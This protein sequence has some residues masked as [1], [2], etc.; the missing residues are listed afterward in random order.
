MPRAIDLLVDEI[1]P[2][3][4]RGKLTDL[5]GSNVNDFLV[6]L[7][8]NY[9]DQYKKIS[10]D[11]G[12]L[13][14][15]AAYIQGETLGLED[16]EPVVDKPLLLAAMNDEIA[17]AKQKLGNTDQFKK[18][19]ESIWVKY[20]DMMLKN[21]MAGAK[22]TNNKIGH[23]VIS[24]ARGKPSQM[25]AMLTTP[26]LYADSKGD[27]VPMFVENS[28]A[29]G[30][31]PLEFAAGMF[32]ARASV[33]STKA[34]TA[35][36]GDYGKLLSQASARLVVTDK[37]CGVQ[38]GLAY[39][40]DD[41]TARNRVLAK[42]VGNFKA[43]TLLTREVIADLKKSNVNKVVARSPLT[44][45]ADGLCSQCVGV[46]F[47]KRFPK[48]GE[49]IGI[50][51]A[52]ALS[53][54][55]TQGALC[56]AKGTMV[57]MANYS[58]KAIEDINIG[59]IVLGADKEGN[60]FA[61]RV[62][63]TFNQGIKSVYSTSFNIGSSSQTVNIVATLDHKILSNVKN[64]GK[65]YFDKYNGAYGFNSP[66]NYAAQ[67]LPLSTKNKEFSAVLLANNQQ[68]G[69]INNTALF[70]GIFAGDGIKFSTKN[71]T[72]DRVKFSCADPELISDLN[73]YLA[74][75]GMYCKK[76][77]RGFDYSFT[78]LS[79]SNNT[80]KDST[81]GKFVSSEEVTHPLK[82]A[83]I[84]NEYA[85]KY[86]YEKEL[87]KE[88][89][90]WDKSSVYEFIAG[91]LATDGCIKLTKNSA[92]IS[93]ASTSKKLIEG[94]KLL[95]RLR[96]GIYSSKIHK[97]DRDTRTLYTLSINRLDQVYKLVTHLN[98]P[99][100]KK[101]K[102]EAVKALYQRSK[103]RHPENFVRA[104]RS[105]VN[106]V[107]EVECYDI[108]V[109]HEDHLFV[110]E[111]NMIVSNSAK[112]TGGQ[113]T[114]KGEYGGF[115]ILSQFVQSPSE[116]IHKAI[117]SD[118]DGQVSQIEEAPQGGY[119]VTINNKP[120]YVKPGYPLTVKVGQN[121]EAGTP[122][123]EGIVDARDVVEKVGLGA[124]RKYWVD[125]IQKIYKDS[126]LYADKKNLEIVA[127]GTLATVSLNEEIE[128]LDA[129]ADD[130]IN[131][132][133][134]KKVW[135]PQ[136]SVGKPIQMT[137]NKYLTKDTLEHTIG[138][139]ITPSIQKQLQEVG[140]NELEV[141]ED[142]PPFAPNMDRLRTASHYNDD[143]LA[144]LSTSYLK[145]QLED[146]ALRAGTTNV[147]ENIH[148]AP[149]VAVG[150]GFGENIKQT[151]KF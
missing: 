138:T 33:I 48:I 69:I 78:Y 146:S 52:N 19:R 107:G 58:V 27:I 80:F 44:C 96:L 23:A 139:R 34:A 115:P 77:K 67:V 140:F 21:T 119:N 1:V 82:R 26:G 125:R 123:S 46:T 5:S 106:Y 30:L 7:Y 124:G 60:A 79:T 99:G 25:Q 70:L 87:P 86:C 84:D 56:L 120:Y 71:N 137:T 127:R 53:E 73:S 50:T 97:R 57:R 108:E 135:K 24:G 100:I 144:G 130:T 8:T 93:F 45:N 3:E 16:F 110:L 68:E 111:N 20:N 118:E 31:R 13:G 49:H 148:W 43:G 101:I 116:Y 147:K 54:P 102:A 105:Q 63:N 32:G 39:D 117:T 51:A 98:I 72:W 18:A 66:E 2:A 104:K 10:H 103:L 121:I 91:Y 113:A 134:V 11:L 132:N 47:E 112:H 136:N 133:K 150:V 12:R 65:I 83:L 128:G 59:D 17:A 22:A 94:L 85:D 122:L 81:T 61:V 42:D 74:Q 141:S 38:N 88:I 40:I 29:E 89:Y 9:P 28:F 41:N 142:P 76:L 4:L 6:D 37:D 62:K 114:Q 64:S 36:G 15:K 149:R 92:I 14:A 90:N 145:K 129:Y 109:D 131:Y 143:W 95:M 55:V 151:G 126:G 75:F 35:K